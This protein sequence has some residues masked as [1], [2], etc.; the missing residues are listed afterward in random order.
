[1]RKLTA[2][3]SAALFLSTS[4]P[5]LAQ[6]ER[7]LGDIQRYGGQWR[8]QHRDWSALHGRP[9]PGVCWEWDD[10]MGQWLWTCSG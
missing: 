1:M 2:M 8:Y 3:I 6:G 4:L 9:N 7:A 5:A 10:R